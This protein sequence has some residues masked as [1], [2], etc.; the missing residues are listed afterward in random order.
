MSY[1]MIFTEIVQSSQFS[2]M[3]KDAQLIYFLLI[4]MY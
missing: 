4:N 2:R 3:S 1:K